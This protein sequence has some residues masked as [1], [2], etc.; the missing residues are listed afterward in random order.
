MTSA[1][2]GHTLR[3]TIAFGYVPAAHA[4]ETA[5]NLIAFGRSYDATRGGRTLYDPKGDRL[6]S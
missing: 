6:K 2:F 1:G 5:F 4:R 3:K